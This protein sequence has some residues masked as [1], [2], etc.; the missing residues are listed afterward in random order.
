[1][2]QIAQVSVDELRNHTDE[3]DGWIAL[4][5]IVW[6]FSGFAGKHPGGEDIIKSYLGNDGSTPYNEIHSP[7]LVLRHLGHEKRVGEL[8]CAVI[9]TQVK[10]DKPSQ[11]DMTIKMPSLASIMNISQFEE[12]AASVLTEKAW[13]YI[14]SATEDGITH[15]ANIGQHSRIM[16]RPRV[17]KRVGDA[18]IGTRFMGQ[19]LSC[20][21]LCAPT[22]SIKL[23]HPDGEIAIAKASVACGVPPIIPSMGSYSVS[24]VADAIGSNL[25]FYFQ[26]Y[27][28]RDRS[29]T[30]KLLDEVCRL[31]V[32]GIM[33][34][35]DSPVLSK[36]EVASTRLP[37]GESR[38][39]G[40]SKHAPP[41]ANTIIDPNLTWQDIEWIIKRTKLPV[42]LKG[43][44][45]AEDA[46]HALA[47]GCA[48]VYLSNHGGRAL[49]TSPPALLVLMEI[50]NNC[51]EILNR[52][53]V[54]VDGGFR[55][56]SDILK[57]ICLGASVVCLG[58]PFLY[59]LAY[60]EAGAIRA[61][62]SE[63]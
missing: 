15:A 28:N 17:L 63:F 56:G 59:A 40:G 41:P 54:I 14:S 10:D 18:Q 47:I 33:V 22:S 27:V 2:S 57:A 3:Q 60:G 42:V 20:P 52:L 43:I 7:G 62:E 61:F 35:V 50:Q 8:E 4:N 34:T 38:P 11:Q 44:Q 53:E 39:G 5:G 19:S 25:P 32:R 36:R 13:T 58:R 51:P 26:L 21:I 1:M 48:G 55:R 31:N 30:E 24:E 49:D 45:H 12:V 16:F 6:D 46:K 23:T 29:E 9:D 37:T